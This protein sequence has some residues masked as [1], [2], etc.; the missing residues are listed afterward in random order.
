L[1]H[2][3]LGLIELIEDRLQFLGSHAHSMSPC[4]RGSSLWRDLRY[5]LPGQLTTVTMANCGGARSML[6]SLGATDNIFV[7]VRI[8]PALRHAHSE[9]LSK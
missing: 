5:A 6:T 4:L 8:A 1:E 9:N 2:F 3:F 7:K